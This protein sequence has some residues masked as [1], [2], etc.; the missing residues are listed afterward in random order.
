MRGLIDDS[1]A[2]TAAYAGYLLALFREP[3]G[4]AALL[5][6]AQHTSDADFVDRLVYRAIATLDDPQYIPTL[7]QIYARL[8]KYE[9]GD[10]YWTIR[11]MGGPQ[12]LEFRKEIRREHGMSALR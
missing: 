7:R 8:R 12:A 2:E 6:F 4:M 11:I 10:F 3:Q 1:D 5:R 9:I